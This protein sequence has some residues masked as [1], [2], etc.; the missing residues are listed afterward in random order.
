MRLPIFVRKPMQI[1][2]VH[3][4]QMPLL[5]NASGSVAIHPDRQIH[6]D[7]VPGPV[8]PNAFSYHSM[9]PPSRLLNL[10]GMTQSLA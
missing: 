3:R 2:T 5:C 9:L 6:H 8:V 1:L 4:K 7:H 10:L